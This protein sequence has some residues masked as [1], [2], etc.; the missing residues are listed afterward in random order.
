[1][2][3]ESRN[4]KKQHNGSESWDLGCARENCK[5]TWRGG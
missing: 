2:E 1:M 4:K 3:R 5:R